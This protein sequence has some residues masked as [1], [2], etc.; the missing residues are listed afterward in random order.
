MSLCWVSH[1]TECRNAECHVILSVVMLSVTVLTVALSADMLSNFV[2]KISMLSIM[3]LYHLYTECHY[4]S[5]VIQSV[6]II[7]EQVPLNKSSLLLKI[8]K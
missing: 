1:Y 6:I 4:R 2:M 7:I 3:W 5:V 8:Q